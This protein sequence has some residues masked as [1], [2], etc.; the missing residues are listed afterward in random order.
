MGDVKFFAVA[1]LWLGLDMMPVFFFM[2]GLF[3]VLLGGGW[4]FFTGKSGLFPF[5][6]ALI[7]A[8]LYYCQMVPDLI[9]TKCFSV[10]LFLILF[11]NNRFCLPSVC[12]FALKQ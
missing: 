7:A 10:S 6:P 4:R 9:C 3:G 12:N 11:A 1:G 2:S 5:G 8:M